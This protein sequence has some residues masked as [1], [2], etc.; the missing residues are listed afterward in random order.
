MDRTGSTIAAGLAGPLGCANS[1]RL[2]HGPPFGVVWCV[3][4]THG[5]PS[6]TGSPSPSKN[7]S[8][9]AEPTVCDFCSVY[10]T[11]HEVYS[12]PVTLRLIQWSSVT[13]SGFA[14]RRDTASSGRSNGG[15]GTRCTQE[16][17]K[18]V[19]MWYTSRLVHGYESHGGLDCMRMWLT[20]RATAS[21]INPEKQGAFET[22]CLVWRAL[23]FSEVEGSGGWHHHTFQPLL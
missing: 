9:R 14:P 15:A 16:Q 5:G 4:A 17:L 1:S 2:S 23:G 18:T 11:I 22:R 19:Q 6:R 20:V 12:P 21:K 8:Q 10:A 13:A 7:D 3:A